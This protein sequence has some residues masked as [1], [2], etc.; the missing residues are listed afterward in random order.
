MVKVREGMALIMFLCSA[1]MV[2]HIVGDPKRDGRSERH[3]SHLGHNR[4]WRSGRP[5]HHIGPL[6]VLDGAVL[7]HRK[8]VFKPPA[9]ADSGDAPWDIGAVPDQ[10]L[11]AK[12]TPAPT[13][14]PTPAPPT[15]QPFM[16]DQEETAFFGSSRNTPP[17]TPLPTPLP[18]PPSYQVKAWERSDWEFRRCTEFN[19]LLE[20]YAA[21]HN[22]IMDF[23]NDLKPH[24]RKFLAI[25]HMVHGIGN[26]Y[27]PANASLL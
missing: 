13:T 9:E 24:E 11:V 18:T 22:R 23:D 27:G 14:E 1:T 16:S 19:I 10:T 20:N 7:T 15:P 12:K 2:Y 5:R 26:R 25:K 3:A 4:K 8:P 21:L 17:P 6:E